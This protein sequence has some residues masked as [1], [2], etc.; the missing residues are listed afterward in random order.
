MCWSLQESIINVAVARGWTPEPVNMSTEYI[1]TWPKDRSPK[2][3]TL[4]RKMTQHRHSCYHAMIQLSRKDKGVKDGLTCQAWDSY[5]DVCQDA[6]SPG[7]PGRRTQLRQAQTLSRRTNREGGGVWKET[8]FSDS[9]RI[10]IAA[11]DCVRAGGLQ[12]TLVQGRWL[13]GK[14][15]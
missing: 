1:C 6:A 2:H 13:V 4:S 11:P 5:T 15:I 7:L 14:K 3:Q 12:C 8:V 9:D 10:A